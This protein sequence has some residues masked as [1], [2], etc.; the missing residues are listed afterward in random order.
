MTQLLSGIHEIQKKKDCVKELM[1]QETRQLQNIFHTLWSRSQLSFW[2]SEYA[3]ITKAWRTAL[4]AKMC[5]DHNL[6]YFCFVTK[7][8]WYREDNK[9]ITSLKA[10]MYLNL[11]LFFPVGKSLACHTLTS[12]LWTIECLLV[13]LH[14]IW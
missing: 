11:A 1:C 5:K 6:F 13:G 4:C 2:W 7:K 8:L 14:R 9:T 3:N 12:R 10:A